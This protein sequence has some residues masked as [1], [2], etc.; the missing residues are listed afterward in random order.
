M[1]FYAFRVVT[2]IRLYKFE[3]AS[4]DLMII[5]HRRHFSLLASPARFQNT[6][7]VLP[8]YPVLP[9]TCAGPAASTIRSH[10]RH[11]KI[12]GLLGQI[13]RHQHTFKVPDE[14]DIMVGWMDENCD[15]PTPFRERLAS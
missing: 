13:I 3:K 1:A 2:C 14:K 15:T 6:H 10:I 4:H 8:A 7:V 5:D 9:V 12:F 11:V